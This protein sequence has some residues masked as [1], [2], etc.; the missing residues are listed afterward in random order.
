MFTIYIIKIAFI[1]QKLCSSISLVLTPLLT[2]AYIHGQTSINLPPIYQG[3]QDKH[4]YYKKYARLFAITQLKA[5]LRDMVLCMFSGLWKFQTN[6]T[7]C[8]A[9]SLG[10][11]IKILKSKYNGKLKNNI[12]AF[13]L[14]IYLL[15]NMLPNR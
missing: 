13:L 11:A 3:K 15:L 6:N 2:L 12:Y 10:I 7:A 8:P 5:G 4:L 9:F 1:F 14:F